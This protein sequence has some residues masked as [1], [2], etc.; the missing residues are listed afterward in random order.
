MC[1]F[2]IAV[3]DDNFFRLSSAAVGLSCVFSSVSFSVSFSALM[4]F[5]VC[6]WMM[7][8]PPSSAASVLTLSSDDATIKIKTILSPASAHTTTISCC[9][10]CCSGCR[11]QIIALLLLTKYYLSFYCIHTTEIKK[12]S[13]RFLFPIHVSGLKRNS[14][15]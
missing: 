9:C 12:N 3:A 7:A 14:M 10:C 13:A 1:V 6:I 11:T 4:V 5:F 8:S 15:V 2:I